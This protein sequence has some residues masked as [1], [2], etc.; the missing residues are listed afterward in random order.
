MIFG[1]VCKQGLGIL[2]MLDDCLSPVFWDR[3][4]SGTELMFF[5]GNFVH[6]SK[7]ANYFSFDMNGCEKVMGKSGIFESQRN[8]LYCHIFTAAYLHLE[9]PR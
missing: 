1:K 6:I 4:F 7:T 5:P 8:D 2:F 3:E 9:S